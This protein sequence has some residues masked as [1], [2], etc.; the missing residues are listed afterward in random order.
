MNTSKFV[1]ILLTSVFFLSTIS[2]F[3]S[4][5]LTAPTP[6]ATKMTTGLVGNQT[7][8]ENWPQ[9][10]SLN[11]AV[12]ARSNYLVSGSP[13]T[14]DK[15]VKSLTLA[16]TINLVLGHVDW[17]MA[18]SMTAAW[19]PILGGLDNS[20]M[21]N[22]ITQDVARGDYLDALYVA[23][24][25]DLN[26]YSSPTV[27]SETQTALQMMPMNKGLPITTN[28]QSYGDPNPHGCYLVYHRF[29]IPSYQYAQ[30]YGL[31]EKWNL[32]QAFI[33]FSTA[34]NTPP[35]GSTFGE[36]LWCDPQYN[37]AS[38]YL[39]RYYD[40]CAQTLSVFLKLAQA[41]VPGAMDYAD[42]VWI[43][44]QD[45][46]TGTLYEYTVG[47]NTVECEMGNFAQI[48]AEYAQQK[49]GFQNVPYWDRII[50]DLDYK[51]LANGWSSP[52]WSSIGV[53][54][55]A[56]GN[57]QTRLY[58][59]MG[60]N[61]A[62]QNFY[63]HFTSSAQS[64]YQQMLLGTTEAWRGLVS[65]NLYVNGHFAPVGGASPN[66]DATILGAGIL[67]LYGIVPVTGHVVTPMREEMCNDYRTQ[68]Q[69]SQFQFDYINQR[70]RI[71]VSR[72]QLIFI[73]GSK[74]VSYT[75]PENG[76]YDIQ[77][78]SD[79]NQILGVNGGVDTIGDAAESADAKFPV[80]GFA[81]DDLGATED[82]VADVE[83][84]AFRLPVP[85]SQEN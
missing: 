27:S 65:S 13:V 72:G 47:M 66:N 60:A 71:P 15:T 19:G 54:V 84:F 51:L 3:K 74:P 7:Y 80:F 57:P 40:E 85:A 30:Q 59:T 25:A 11:T 50:Q 14:Y 81:T 38:S 17:N 48:I 68:F 56:D 63:S 76:I 83:A 16:D 1:G 10:S 5:S 45:H 46:W 31:T 34:Y 35:I 2:D 78:S 24:L 20:A 32:T 62:L 22:A 21:D 37:W 4:M 29:I 18:D 75:F 28:V 69:Y 33:D 36:M 43:A 39:S 49:G 73:Y 82:P 41:G 70:I 42:K 26:G 6:T 9:T 12:S 58:E 23:R 53:I 8:A 67:F 77:F 61:L 52:G 55:H 79:W 44:M 64:T